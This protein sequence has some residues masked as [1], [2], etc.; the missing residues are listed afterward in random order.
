MRKPKV[1]ELGNNVKIEVW[2]GFNTIGG[3]CIVI[4]DRDEGI[5]FDQGLCFSKFK[6]F[7]GGAI[8]PEIVEDLREIGAIPPREVYEGISEIYISHF[9]IDHLGSL[10]IPFEYDVDLFIPSTSVFERLSRFWTLGWKELLLPSDFDLTDLKD[11]SKAKRAKPIQVSHSAYPS[12]SYIIETSEGNILYTGDFRVESPLKINTLENF[13][14]IEERVDVVII[15]GTNFLRRQT[16]LTSSDAVRILERVLGKYERK[17]IFLSAHP[18]DMESFLLAIRVL[19]KHDFVP[20]LTHTKYAE[21]L[22]AQLRLLKLEELPKFYLLP[23][24]GG[25]PASF[26]FIE[27][28]KKDEVLSMGKI[29]FLT[30]LTTV[31]ELKMLIEICN[32]DPIGLIQ[33]TLI[34]EPLDE[35]GWILEKRLAN[36]LRKLGITPFRIHLSG[37]YQ[38]YEFKEILRTIKPKRV[39]PIHTRA[40][41]IV[42]SLFEKFK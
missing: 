41:E 39:I 30:S 24:K 37:H 21:L 29:A 36:W 1:F 6:K 15:E 7:Y 12:Y 26:H 14:N 18:I 17:Y 2:G 40:P 9:H 13:S 27:I 33:I 32:I 8:Q 25:P 10:A 19:Q 4:R 31:N 11:V 16:P 28:A 38:P 22:D 3:N 23:L 5:M 42:I 34:G 20:V 35:E